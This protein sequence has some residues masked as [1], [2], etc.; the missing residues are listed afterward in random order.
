MSTAPDFHPGFQ[1]HAASQQMYAPENPQQMQQQLPQQ[2]LQ[3]RRQT[4]DAPVPPHPQSPRPNINLFAQLADYSN[5]V[6]TTPGGIY[7][8]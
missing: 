2:Q 6:R 5:K 4:A 8:V 7:L 3:T 1:P